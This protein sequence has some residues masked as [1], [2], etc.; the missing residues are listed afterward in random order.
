MHGIR[1]AGGDHPAI[2]QHTDAI[3][4][5]KNNIHVVF[6]QQHGEVVL[7]YQLQEQIEALHASL[8]LTT[9]QLQTISQ[10]LAA[11]RSRMT[12]GA[13]AASTSARRPSIVPASTPNA[14]YCLAGR[15]A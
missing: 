12:T 2:H 7:G 14:W 4:Q 9:R 11:S 10:E 5:G 8:E 13:R 15:S 3:G 1:S 6:D